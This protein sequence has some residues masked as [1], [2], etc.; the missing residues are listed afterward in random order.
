VDD[1]KRVLHNAHLQQQQQQG[2][3]QCPSQM[4]STDGMGVCIKMLAS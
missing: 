2:H 3:E 4:Q 1:V